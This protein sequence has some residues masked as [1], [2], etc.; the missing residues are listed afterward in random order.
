MHSLI[1]SVQGGL[2]D[3]HV[4]NVDVLNQKKKNEEVAQCMTDA[5]LFAV[6][7]AREYG[8]RKNIHRG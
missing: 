8:E 2:K 4:I 3:K 7:L 5:Y 6:Q 1:G